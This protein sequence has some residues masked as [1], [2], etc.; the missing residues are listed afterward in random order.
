MASSELRKLYPW[1]IVAGLAVGGLVILAF[2]KDQFREWKEW[3]HAYIKQEM[4]R[5]TNEAQRAAAA[6][7][8]VE[9]KQI[10]LPDVGR[11]DRCTTCHLAVD[12]ASYS[13]F[14][15]PL[16]YH[17]NHAQHP[18]E[19][20]ACTICHQGQGLAA[21]R[22]AAHGHVEHWERPMLPMKYIEASCAKCHLA[23]DISG[24]PKLAKGRALFDEIG[25][26][27]CHKLKG[28][29]GVIGPELDGVG[30]RRSPEWLAK[31]FRTPAAVTPGSA[32]P[33]IKVTD[34]EI[35]A[36]TLY[37]LSLTEE[38]LDAY[39]T[40]MQVLP[41]PEAGQRLFLEKGCIGCHSLG[42][43][44][45]KVGP[46]LEGL[47]GRRDATWI[48]AHFRNPQ[49]T[50]P[51]TMMPKFDFTEAQIRALTE[52]LLTKTEP[53][54]VNLLK[55]PAQMTPIERGKA[56]FKKYGCAG[57]HG[58]DAMSGVPNPNAKTAQQVPGLK[59]VSEGYN[60][61]ELRKRILGGQK[62]INKLNPKG[63][64]PPLYMPAWGGK[65]SEGEL[66]DLVEYLM[67]LLP[68]TEKTD[69]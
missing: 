9:I 56:V 21:T 1:F 52:F 60:K 35:D 8:P 42:G 51:G 25:C 63:P 55:F 66:D 19:K 2:Y 13:G 65:I 34:E 36:L 30:A 49:A 6:L 67:S 43:Q 39:Y 46:A 16:A 54:A 4:A 18:F 14:K 27:G 58:R 15:Q 29:G 33:P 64:Q 32:M 68:K 5:A 47:K 10:V 23:S 44:G 11:I 24:A 59:F 22:E 45:G 53:G 69:F 7:I 61:A 37:M 41:G 48:A 40:S 28:S 20:F 12:D 50:T 26:I 62:E 17:P 57:C 31:H 3:Q 38:R